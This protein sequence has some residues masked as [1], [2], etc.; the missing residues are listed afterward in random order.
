MA[1]KVARTAYSRVFLIEGTA[2]PDHAPAYKSCLRLTALSR[3]YG[4]IERI[5]CPDPFSYGQFIEV[6]Q[7]KGASERPTSSLEGHYPLDITSDLLRLS[8]QGCPFDIQVHF[9][10]CTDP[11]NFEA[12]DKV[13]IMESAYLSN[14]A[15]EDLGALQSGDNAVINETGDVSSTD[16]YEA[17]PLGYA[18]KASSIVTLEVKDVVGCDSISCGE[19]TQESN[20]CKKFYA[21]TIAAGGSPGTPPDVVFTLDGGVTW[22][23]HDIDALSTAQDGTAIECFGDNV[24][25]ISYQANGLAWVDKDDLNSYT[26][27]TWALVTTGFVAAK[28]PRNLWSAG[29]YLFI[30]GDGGYVYGTAD[31]TAGVTVLDAGTATADILLAV[32]GL[33]DSFAVAVGMDGAI[34]KTED[35]ATWTALTR[36]VG[37]GVNLN[38]VWVLSEFVWFIGTSTGRLYYTT[39]GGTTWTEKS[40]T[41]SGTGSVLSLYFPKKSVGFMSHQTSGTKGRILSTWNGGN[42]WKLDPRNTGTFPANDKLN[43]LA[44]C[45]SDPNFV[46][47]VGLAD[48]A[49]DGYILVGDAD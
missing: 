36:P 17:V 49:A 29:N 1:N 18:A 8:K 26:D 9:G 47:G 30:V 43:A 40:F 12:A 39:N 24:V 35:G 41:G 28:A 14:Y 16:A 7:I 32:H 25:V 10:E 31:P 45:V 23:A 44:G 38:T 2:F 19:C 6:A 4:D 21:S 46:V 15:T 27:P 22:Y 34:I 11:S 3:G 20:G 37:V 42:T 48:D 13:V 5:E 33:S